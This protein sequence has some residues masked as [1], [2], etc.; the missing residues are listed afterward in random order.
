M[1]RN[2]RIVERQITNTIRYYAGV[3]TIGYIGSV[4]YCSI[5][6]PNYNPSYSFRR[7]LFDG[8]TVGLFVGS[9]WPIA[10]PIVTYKYMKDI[11]DSDPIIDVNKNH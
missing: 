7:N 2:T 6:Q 1:T 11:V 4:A 3:Y 9:I 10:I 5:V 8:L